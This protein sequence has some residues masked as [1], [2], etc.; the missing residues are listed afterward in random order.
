MEL[1]IQAKKEEDFGRWYQEVVTK[2]ELIDYTD[3][4]GC[5][6]LR[7]NAY[8]IW[9]YIKA[10]LDAKIK[11]VGVKNCY[12]P[13]FITKSALEK[14]STHLDDFTP[15]VAWVTRSG[16]SDLDEPLAVRPTSETGMYPLY[17]KWI[18]R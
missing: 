4:G 17:A 16:Q 2:A 3:V 7:P 11:S 5:Y 8:E 1:G 14:E 6:V 18:R 15:E 12:F 9:E 10:D 13:L